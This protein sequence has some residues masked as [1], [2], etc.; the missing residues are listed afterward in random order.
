MLFVVLDWTFLH[1]L[2]KMR[3]LLLRGES[4]PLGSMR[5]VLGLAL[6]LLL[7]A[8]TLF[9]PSWDKRKMGLHYM[10]LCKVGKIQVAAQYLNKLTNWKCW[11]ITGNAK[12]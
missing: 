5:K 10:G 6:G 12:D 4:N 2:L 3:G 1:V 9:S 7:M 11:S 8:G